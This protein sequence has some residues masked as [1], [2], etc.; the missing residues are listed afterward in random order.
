M[1]IA[2]ASKNME[3]SQFA[4]KLLISIGDLENVRN[5]NGRKDGDY[6]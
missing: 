5:T 3:L 6:V 2:A 1:K 4:K